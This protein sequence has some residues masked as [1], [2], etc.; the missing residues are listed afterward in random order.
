METTLFAIVCDLQFTIRDHLRSSAIIWKPAFNQIQNYQIM[1]KPYLA[2]FNL[3][4]YLTAFTIL[5]LQAISKMCNVSGLFCPVYPLFSLYVIT[6]F[7][8]L[9]RRFL[10]LCDYLQRQQAR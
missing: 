9:I 2:N 3:D 8:G 7:I 4:V 6:F 1:S 10:N 5:H